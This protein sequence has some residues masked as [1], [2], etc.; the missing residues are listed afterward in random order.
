MNKCRRG[1]IKSE[2]IRT[3]Y[4][5]K[6]LL[7]ELLIILV[8]ILS[9]YEDLAYILKYSDSYSVTEYIIR[10]IDYDKFKMIIIILSSFI[11]TD[12]YCEDFNSNYINAVNSRLDIKSYAKCKFTVNTIVSGLA[13]FTPMLLFSLLLRL[14]VPLYS[15]DIL[16]EDFEKSLYYIMAQNNLMWLYLILV[17]IIFSIAV[18]FLNGI[19][20]LL[21]AYFPNKYV[22]FSVP[23][24]SFYWIST[25]TFNFYG[26]FQ[27]L[28]LL[29]IN[30]YILDSAILS[31]VYN[32][33][34][35]FIVLWILKHNF[36]KTV[37]RRNKG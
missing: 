32:F 25:L 3:V 18:S 33:L 27:F 31:I 5:G 23:F 4:S 36:I 14:K 6:F 8:C 11:Y 22:A 9:G 24:I 17:L 35:F 10:I 12:S 7:I 29:R 28:A 34:I 1:F 15:S 21:S 37:V 16:L 19:G 26:E 13:V 2:I 30:I 20:I